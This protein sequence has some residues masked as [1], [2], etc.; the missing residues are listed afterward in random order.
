MNGSD[1]RRVV[2]WRAIDTKNMDIRN[3][4]TG[5]N[6]VLAIQ[7]DSNKSFIHRHISLFRLTAILGVS[8]VC[9][10]YVPWIASYFP[11]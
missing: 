3:E 10:E 11:N 4:N 7:C 1:Q 2:W 6:M 8:A 9:L 5:S